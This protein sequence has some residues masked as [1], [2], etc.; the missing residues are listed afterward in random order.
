MKFTGPVENYDIGVSIDQD[1]VLT[2]KCTKKP[3]WRPIKETGVVIP[4]VLVTTD[5][6]RLACKLIVRPDEILVTPR[7]IFG[8]FEPIKVPVHE[9]EAILVQVRS[10]SE[11]GF[12]IEYATGQLIFF[13]EGFWPGKRVNRIA[14]LIQDMQANWYKGTSVPTIGITIVPKPGTITANQVV[15]RPNQ[16]ST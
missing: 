12:T 15:H 16:S 13:E 5:Y 7:S 9:L 10:W 4:T 11:A 2:T 8:P 6:K 1:G 14:Q 3:T